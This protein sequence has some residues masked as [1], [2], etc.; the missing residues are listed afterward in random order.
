MYQG[1]GRGKTEM[2]WYT[3][4]GMPTLQGCGAE[5]EISRPYTRPG[6]KA[7]GWY[8][9]WPLEPNHRDAVIGNEEEWHEDKSGGPESLL[10]F[11]PRCHKIMKGEKV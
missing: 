10:T 7:S 8:V 9:C 4:D 5:I 1:Q 2:H 3:C 6:V 11:C